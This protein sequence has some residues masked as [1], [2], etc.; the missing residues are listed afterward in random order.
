M[1][2]NMAKKEKVL[3]VE[4]NLTKKITRWLDQH[5]S[6]FGQKIL[7]V[8]TGAG[9]AEHLSGRFPKASLVLLTGSGSSNHKSEKDIHTAHTAHGS[10]PELQE[11]LPVP[12]QLKDYEGGLFDTVVYLGG[13]SLRLPAP[14]RTIPSWER[15]T[16]YLRRASLLMECYEEEAQAL[17][18]HIRPGGS[19]LAIVRSEHD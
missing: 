2:I 10:T 1:D 14:G 15:G 4:N 19:L 7:C 16:L 3:P 13:S 8:G 11:Y 5:S 6:L 12:G 18:R 17:R 9:T